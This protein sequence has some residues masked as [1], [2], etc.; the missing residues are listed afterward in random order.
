MKPKAIAKITNIG[1]VELPGPGDWATKFEPRAKT[2]GKTAIPTA[3]YAWNPVVG[4]TIGCRYCFARGMIQR[5]AGE[6]YKHE[7]EYCEHHGIYKDVKCFEAQ[8]IFDKTHVRFKNFLPQLLRFQYHKRFPKKPC[9]IAVG[10][11]S[12]ISCWNESDLINV[13]RRIKVNPSHRFQFLT[14]RPEVYDRFD[15]PDNCWLGVTVTE[16]SQVEMAKSYLRSNGN[17]VKFLY[18]E[19]LEVP[20]DLG[21]LGWVDWVVAGGKNGRGTVPT[22]EDTFS[23]VQQQC[24]DA[25]VPFFFKGPGGNVK[26]YELKGKK[27][28]GFPR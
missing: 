23:E 25:G 22:H 8:E 27:Y 13:I 2:I 3:D 16:Q 14:K 6:Y 12:D 5:F 15:F 1:G 24:Q 10:W 26:D 18:L 7:M 11:M 9:N 28:K 21:Y 20:I 19:P 4:C 17:V